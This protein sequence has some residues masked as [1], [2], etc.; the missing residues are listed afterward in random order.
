M[1]ELSENPYEKRKNPS[2]RGEGNDSG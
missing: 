1:K 2:Y